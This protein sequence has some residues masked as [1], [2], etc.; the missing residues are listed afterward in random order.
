MT[1]AKD[2][3]YCSNNF[4][5]LQLN[6]DG[7]DDDNIQ[8]LGHGQCVVEQR[9]LFTLCKIPPLWRNFA[10]GAKYPLVIS[11]DVIVQKRG[12]FGEHC[13]DAVT[14]KLLDKESQK[15]IYMSAVRPIT[16]GNPNHR[17]TTN[18]GESGSSS[19]SSEGTPSKK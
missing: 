9:E 10:W 6:S 7:I 15:I 11:H 8:S 1:V 16:K 3:F 5:L 2:N 14:H 18:G 4:L 13:G 17:L 19:G 12:G